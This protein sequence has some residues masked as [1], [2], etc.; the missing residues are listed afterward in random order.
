MSAATAAGLIGS[1]ASLSPLTLESTFGSAAAESAAGPGAWEAV[2]ESMS[3]RAA[4]YQSQITGVAT[5][6]AYVVN[7]VKFDGFSNGE[8]LDAKG[9]GYANFVE[10]GEFKPFFQGADDLVAQAQRQVVAA[11]GTPITWHVAEPEAATAMQNL[12][13]ESGITGIKVVHTSIVP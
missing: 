11:D 3:A 12:L 13:S 7:G 2:S 1:E 6:E 4:A 8:L 5:D 9:P 10:D